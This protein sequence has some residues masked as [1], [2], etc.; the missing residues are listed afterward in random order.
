MLVIDDGAGP[1]HTIYLDRAGVRK[2]W[3]EY[4]CRQGT[5]NATLVAGEM[6]DSVTL[7][8]RAESYSAESGISK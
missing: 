7:T 4:D 8:A 5:V 2:G 3:Y 1:V 6:S